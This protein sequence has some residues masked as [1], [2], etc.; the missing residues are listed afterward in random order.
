M[1]VPPHQSPRVQNSTSSSRLS[2]LLN[3][4]VLD[5]QH[6]KPKRTILTTFY[7]RSQQRDCVCQRPCSSGPHI[8]LCD[9]DSSHFLSVPLS[10]APP[11]FSERVSH[12]SH[13]TGHLTK[14]R[15]SSNEQPSRRF[16]SASR[17]SPVALPRIGDCSHCSSLLL[18]LV[19]SIHFVTE[20]SSG[21]NTMP[22]HGLS[23][24]SLC[25]GNDFCPQ[26]CAVLCGCTRS[27]RDH[28]AFH[29]LL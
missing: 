5:S 10:P 14:I 6:Q 27:N 19:L 15:T 21:S 16:P 26:V 29:Q 17:P 23:C 20:L 22:F 28:S 2:V 7:G 4:N 9:H 25:T 8:H 24:P 13:C 12:L 1:Q 3:S 18:I 11:V